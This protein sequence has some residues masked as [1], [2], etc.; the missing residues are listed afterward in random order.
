MPSRTRKA[1][2]LGLAFG[3]AALPGL[4]LATAGSAVAA[5]G[6]PSGARP[7]PVPAALKSVDTAGSLAPALK[8]AK[9]TVTVS[10]ALSQKAV[11]ATVAEDSLKT[12]GLPTKAAQQSQSSAVKSQ[13]DQVIGKAKGLGAKTLGRAGKAAN[14]VAMSIPAGKLADLSKIAGVV[15]VKPVAKYEV[16]EDPGGSGSLAQAADYLQATSVRDQGIDG[17]GVKVG[18]IDSGIDYTHANLGGPGTADAYNTCEAGNTAAPTG[19]CATLFGP[20]APKVKGGTDFI[21]ENWPNTD[22]Q[23]DPNPLDAEGH[24]THVSDIIGGRSADGTHKGIAP[25]VDLYA[26]K[27]CSSVSTSCSGVGILEAIDWAMDPNGDGDISD[28]LDIINLSLGSSYGQE[29]D[30]STVAID[31]AVRAGI[32]AVISAGNEA[33]RPFI[34]GSPSTAARAISVAQ[35]ALPDDKL[36]TIATDK[37]ITVRNSKL[38]TWSPSPT[39]TITAPLA[40]PSDPIGCAAADFADFPDGA[41]ALIARG[42][43]NASLKAQNAQDAGAS[44][45]IIYNNVPG[46]PPDFSFGGGDPVTIPTYTTSQADGQALA[47]A[48]AAGAVTVTIDPANTTSLTNTVVGTSSRGPAI[49]GIRAKPDIGAPGAWLSAEVG[50]GDGMTNFGGTSGA[51]PVVSGA[52]AL[53]LDKFPQTTPAIVKARLLNGASTENR[54]PDAQANLYP[55]PVTRVGAGEVR[56]AP[57]V[58]ATGVLLNKALGSGNVGLGLPHLTK[59]T[60]FT[61]AL[62]IRNTGTTAKKYDLTPTFRDPAEANTAVKVDAPNSVTVPAK[63]VTAFT[64]K[65]EIDPKKLAEWPFTHAAGFTGDGSELNAPEFDGLIKAVSGAETLHLG[66]TVLPE[67]SADVS[68]TGSVKAGQKLTLTNASQALDGAAQVFGLTG[69]SPKMPTPAPGTPGSPGSNQ[70]VIDL[71]AAGVRDDVNTD[72]VQFAVAGWQRQTVPLYP[73]GYEIDLDTNRDGTADFAVFQQEAVGFGSSGQSIVVVTNIAT[74]DSS[75]FFFTDANFDSATQV[76][77]APLSALGLTRGSTFDFSVLAFD[78]YFSGVV[79]DV[80]DGQTWTVGSKKFALQGGADEVSV[81]AGGKTALTVSR[82]ATAGET[83]ST[84]LLFLYDNAATR[85]AQAVRVS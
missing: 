29:Q 8:N 47:A 36:Q 1:K 58:N 26:L 22:L 21:G 66:W 4:V 64:V 77:S 56:I 9:G 39:A 32:V 51:A 5:P 43:C 16:H 14:V 11:G 41:V 31:N 37:G 83:T 78:N 74:G 46:D 61:A 6:S 71:Q 81:P 55:T 17:T 59:T 25:G 40:T 7:Q 67:R 44:A 68:T 35:T 85:D 10:V 54:T 63:G 33:D 72:V 13:Q 34:V 84:G 49:S 62:S 24:G 23:P 20:T 76:L 19:L 82:N 57:A 79:S 73:A 80:I 53:I 3:A 70:A 45:V 15:S 50:T 12:G 2:L 38:Q 30:D 60:S 69:T 28:A 27:V 48:V 75:S 18:V 52:A 65:V 42:T